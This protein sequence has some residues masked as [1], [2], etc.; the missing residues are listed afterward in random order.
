VDCALAAS[1][2]MFAATA[3]GLGTC[4]VGLGANISN[5]KMLEAIGIPGDCRIIAPLILGYPLSIPDPLD[6]EEP[7]I[8]KTL[9]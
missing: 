1:Y 4:W 9:Q 5:R 2:F 3:R 7:K 8:L 6:R